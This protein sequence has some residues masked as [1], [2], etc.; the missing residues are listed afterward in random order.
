[1]SRWVPA[2]LL[3]LAASGG[4][5]QALPHRFDLPGGLKVS[6]REDPERVLFRAR[7]RVDLRP[8]D[9]PAGQEGLAQLALRLIDRGRAGHLRPAAFDR[10]LD[11]SGIQLT[12]RLT[13]RA[14][15][16]DL[17]C[18]NRD[19]DRALALLADRVL[20]P[21]MDPSMLDPE[22][23]ACWREAQPD[24]AMPEARLQAAL[25]LE[26]PP[27]LTEAGLG[28]VAFKDVE[29]FRDRVFRPDR[30]ELLLEGDLGLEQA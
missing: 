1:M 4:V 10:A 21:V 25:D 19:Q 18:R 7:L 24:L 9:V 5:A 13:A 28:R 26:G 20:R 12:R 22:R 15:T 2:A 29:A 14:I 8:G 11:E 6:L 23:L 27:P 16:W 17:V 30:A 3:A